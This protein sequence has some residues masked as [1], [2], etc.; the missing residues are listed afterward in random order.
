[1]NFH[2]LSVP[3]ALVL[4]G[5][6]LLC[7]G[8]DEADRSD[9]VNRQTTT[10]RDT[11]QPA[12]GRAEDRSRMGNDDMTAFDQ[13]ESSEHIKITAD[14]RRAIMNDDS[15]STSAK[16]C[17]VVTDA[18]GMVTLSGSV[19]T[20]AEKDAIEAKAKA[21]VGASRVTNRLEVNAS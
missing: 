16:N 11:T 4:A 5:G 20:Q 10:P 3:A 18:N 9:A 17:T 14:V 15:L 1:M 19:N 2:H 7:G 8:C 6:V 13:S 21:V 12:L